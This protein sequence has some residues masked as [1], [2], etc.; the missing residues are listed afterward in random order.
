ME[1]RILLLED[2]TALGETLVELLEERG[3]R[4]DWA[5]DGAE[6]ADFS[7]DTLYDLYLLDINVPEIDGLELLEGLREADDTTPVIFISALVDLNTI[8]R[9]F[10][11]GAEDYIKKPF[12]PEELLIRVEARLTRSTGRIRFGTLEYDP[13][14]RVLKKEGA[15][16]SLGEVQLCLLDLFLKNPGQ[17]I[18]K[19]VLMECLEHPSSAALRVAI[20]K[21]KEK[22]GL[23]FT[24]LRGVGYAV[25]KC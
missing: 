15:L 24:N 1:K 13:L 11:L 18:D 7:F 22:T 23:E 6:A 12:S 20:S 2:D 25:Q 14:R 21:L 16:V 4:V 5:R 19:E 17:V 8:A 10:G 9:G 3:Y